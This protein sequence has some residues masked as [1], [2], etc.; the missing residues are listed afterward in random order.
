VARGRHRPSK[1]VRGVKIAGRRDLTGHSTSTKRGN[2]VTAARKFLNE[3]A[4]S[5]KGN[6]RVG[7]RKGLASVVGKAGRTTR[8]L[9]RSS[10]G[11]AISIPEES[12][13]REKNLSLKSVNQCYTSIKR[14]RK[15]VFG[16]LGEKGTRQESILKRLCERIGKS[17]KT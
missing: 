9:H 14:P 17:R 13:K 4:I 3:T 15:T 5:R 11:I 7:Q 12:G 16:R 6:V 8:G 10:T 1:R 2:Q